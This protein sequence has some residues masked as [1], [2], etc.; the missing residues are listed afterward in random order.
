MQRCVCNNHLAT[1]SISVNDSEGA[2][3]IIIPLCQECMERL[4]NEIVELIPQK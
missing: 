2:P 1:S 4:S 3:F